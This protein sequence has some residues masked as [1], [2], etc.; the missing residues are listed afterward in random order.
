LA[1]VKAKIVEFIEA[2]PAGAR[3][4]PNRIDR[5]PM[6]EGSLEVEALMARFPGEDREDPVAKNMPVE[7]L[8]VTENINNPGVLADLVASNLRLRSRRRNSV[9]EEEDPFR[10]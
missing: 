1:V 7:I 6:K 2:K 10:G 3:P 8:M 9:L 4:D 5:S